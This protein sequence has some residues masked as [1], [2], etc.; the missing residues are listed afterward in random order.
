MSIKLNWSQKIGPTPNYTRF[1]DVVEKELPLQV[2]TWEASEDFANTCESIARALI[3]AGKRKGADNP[4]FVSALLPKNQGIAS[5]QTR[6]GAMRRCA[7][8]FSSATRLA[9]Y[10][11]LLLGG[12]ALA[13]VRFTA[14]EF[15]E[16][17]RT[18]EGGG[19]QQFTLD[20]CPRCWNF[21]VGSTRSIQTVDDAIAHWSFVKAVEYARADF[22]FQLAE[23][24]LASGDCKGARD[25]ALQAVLHVTLED[26]R[27]HLLL[28]E[29]GQRI[30]D[31]T[32]IDEA[33]LTL[34]QMNIPAKGDLLRRAIAFGMA[35]H[36]L[37]A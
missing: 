34:R 23:R 32:L 28:V 17:M 11:Q 29:V 16:S 37:R 31:K 20:R 30:D 13:E 3:A 27:F 24:M 36:A 22:Y 7:V 25:L 15:V 18:L 4:L 6:D 21:A 10:A 14:E 19:I 9:D 2:E 26:P 33:R 5:V 1:S 35:D 8:F 12:I